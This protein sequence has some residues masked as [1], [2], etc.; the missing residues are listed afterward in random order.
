MTPWQQ[1][2][3]EGLCAL[4]GKVNDRGG[5]ALC[6]RCA[7]W[8]TSRMAQIRERWRSE[9]KC[10]RCGRPLLKGDTHARCAAC[11][12]RDREY[13]RKARHGC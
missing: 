9:G 1:R 4:C 2:R 7:K 3:A 12:A 5:R 6:G 13:A 11:R 10:S 8:H